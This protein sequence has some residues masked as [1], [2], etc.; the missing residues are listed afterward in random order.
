MKKKIQKKAPKLYTGPQV[1]A[2]L[3]SKH[4]E[5]YLK[6]RAGC[7]ND[8]ITVTAAINDLEP[9]RAYCLVRA[10]PLEVEP[11]KA[12]LGFGA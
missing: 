4:R 8:H 7:P 2:L 5:W 3:A 6:G 1:A 10:V 11:P 12:T 9:G